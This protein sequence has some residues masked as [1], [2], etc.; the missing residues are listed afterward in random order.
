M[1]TRKLTTIRHLEE[2]GLKAQTLKALKEA[3]VT[4]EELVTAARNDA[5]YRAYAPWCANGAEANQLTA[6]PSI[7]KVRAQEIVEVVDEAGFILH[8]SEASRS[9]RR[10][11]ASTL[12]SP[13]ALLEHY[14]DLEDMA[15]EALAAVDELI[16]E[17]LVDRELRVVQLR[18][19]FEDGKYYTLQECAHI[20]G[21][22]KERVQ[23]LEFKALAKLRHR[24]RRPRL[25][26][27]TCYSREALSRRMAA[28]WSKIG[29]LQEELDALQISS[30]YPELEVAG[31]A[32]VSIEELDPS[33]RTFNCLKRAGI[34]T[35]GELCEYTENDLLNIRNFSARSLEEVL[36]ILQGLGLSLATRP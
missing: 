18:F 36:A 15:S 5:A 26:V 11:L 34:H 16:H 10:L 31:V 20:L 13:T 21:V 28:L 4:A 8:E 27:V 23:Q 14:E 35:V 29:K 6:I 25:E 32:G 2:L 7:G 12:G 17:A 24:S 1:A 3:D 22:T 9:A 19:G 33:V 30:P